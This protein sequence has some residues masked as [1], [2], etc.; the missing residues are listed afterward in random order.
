MLLNHSPRRSSPPSVSK[1]GM[2]YSMVRVH[3]VTYPFSRRLPVP[4]PDPFRHHGTEEAALQ[5]VVQK[6]G[7]ALNPT[8]T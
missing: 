1:K 5:R 3:T 6:S 7:G 8:E 4:H 2:L